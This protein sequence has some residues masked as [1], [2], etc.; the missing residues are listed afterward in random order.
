MEREIT[1]RH[2]RPKIPFRGVER[3]ISI[4]RVDRS[5]I[6]H[7]HKVFDLTL[8]LV[9]LLQVAHHITSQLQ[10][11]R[12][13]DRQIH[14]NRRGDHRIHQYIDTPRETIPPHHDIR[15]CRQ[16]KPFTISVECRKELMIL[17]L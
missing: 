1:R 14:P 5:L 3:E 13:Q 12:L 15:L 17:E 16:P 8:P 9:P 10:L 2:L 4:L 6:R 7:Q 11:T